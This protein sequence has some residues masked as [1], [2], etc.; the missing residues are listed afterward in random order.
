MYNKAK[1]QTMWWGKCVQAFIYPLG[2]PTGTLRRGNNQIPTW[3]WNMIVGRTCL[4][5]SAVQQV[6]QITRFIDWCLSLDGGFWEHSP[7]YSLIKQF[8][9]CCSTNT[10][11]D[12]SNL[13]TFY[14]Y[15]LLPL[16]N[17]SVRIC[18]LSVD[19]LPIWFKIPLISLEYVRG[20]Y[21]CK[22]CW[23]HFLY[24]S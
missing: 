3:I 21:I 17:K 8:V 15:R 22:A 5:S 2:W 6:K 18:E 14:T 1:W 13:L 20:K 9:I 12:C 11:F 7:K 24:L 10:I 19:C 23:L 4:L 16:N